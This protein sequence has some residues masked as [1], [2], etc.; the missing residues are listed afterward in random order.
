MNEACP[1]C[2]ENDGAFVATMC[3][4]ILHFSCLQAWAALSNTCPI[5]RCEV[6]LH[7]VLRLHGIQGDK[8]Y[9][10]LQEE[11][12]ELRRRLV[13]AEQEKLCAEYI[14]R[15]NARIAS[16]ASEQ[17]VDAISKLACME[18]KLIYA[19]ER[20]RLSAKV[21]REAIV[22]LRRLKTRVTYFDTSLTAS[23]GEDPKAP[24][25]DTVAPADD[26]AAATVDTVAGLVDMA[27]SVDMGDESGDDAAAATGDIGQDSG[28][29]VTEDSA[30]EDL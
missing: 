18:A 27:C 22:S 9:L 20:A 29:E 30:D 14:A 13:S 4:H 21:R 12:T 25:N 2:M 24:I 3:G 10:E 16:E 5:C 28:D 1:L 6:D 11:N 7:G 23:L 26:A 17:Y 15:K 8:C 19:R